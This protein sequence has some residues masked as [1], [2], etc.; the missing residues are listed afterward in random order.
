M[1]EWML[2][3]SEQTQAW[4]AWQTIEFGQPEAFLLLIIPLFLWGLSA[5]KVWRVNSDW[6]AQQSSAHRNQFKHPLIEQALGL[7]KGQKLP[8]LVKNKLNFAQFW[9]QSILRLLRIATLLGLV[10][11]AAQPQQVLQINEPQPQVKTVRDLMFVVES[12]ASFLLPDYQINEQPTARMDVVKKVLDQFMAGLAGNRFGLVLYAEQAYTLMP[13]S[14]DLTTAR[15]MLQRLRPYLAGRTDEA[16]GEALGLALRQAQ[17]NTSETQ[18]R[19]LVLISD[20]LSQPSRIPLASVIEYAQA[21]NLPIY[22]IG[23]GAG[24][25]QAD[26]RLYSGLLYQPLESDSLKTLAQKT[27]GKYFSISSGQ[28]LQQVL[29]II[30]K[31]EGVKIDQPIQRKQVLALFEWPLLLG[32]FAF[33]LYIQLRFMWRRRLQSS[34]R[35]SEEVGHVG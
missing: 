27:G 32:G 4:M 12:S 18:K 2:R 9:R 7:K 17:N 1:T 28:D 19:I 6:Q 26:Q 30:D 25:A 13:L 20:G 8:G 29:Q 24:S 14:D 33:V 35:L 21:M 31:T 11:A 5:L 22:T 3:L 23:V 15:L 10:I 34:A 16:M